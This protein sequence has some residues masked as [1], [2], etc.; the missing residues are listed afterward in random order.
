MISGRNQKGRLGGT[1][2]RAQI[3]FDLH[4]MG[5][6]GGLGKQMLEGR[7]WAAFPC[8]RSGTY[9]ALQHLPRRTRWKR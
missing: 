4:S 7:W 8:V 1:A 3:E 5:A 9:F 2:D 6:A